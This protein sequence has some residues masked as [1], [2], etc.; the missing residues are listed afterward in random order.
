MM[1]SKSDA[2]DLLN[3][4]FV[5]EGDAR[6]RRRDAKGTQVLAFFSSGRLVSESLFVRNL[7]EAHRAN[8]EL[9]ELG[10]LAQRLLH[11]TRLTA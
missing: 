3:A 9:E 2:A 11:S 8:V 5:A 4:V 6:A 7:D 10:R 1:L